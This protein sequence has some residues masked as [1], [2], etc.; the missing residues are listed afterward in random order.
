MVEGFP[1][2][3]DLKADAKNLEVFWSKLT[4]LFR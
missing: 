4:K 3:I 2:Q 1:Q